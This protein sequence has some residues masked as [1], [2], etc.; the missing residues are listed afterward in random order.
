MK[1]IEQHLENIKRIQSELHESYTQAMINLD[2]MNQACGGNLLNGDYI[3]DR[4]KAIQYFANGK[5]KLDY[6]TPDQL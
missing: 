5:H 2:V 6:V 3:M 1:T 4:E